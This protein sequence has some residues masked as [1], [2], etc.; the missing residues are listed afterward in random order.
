MADEIRVN[1]DEPRW[2]Q[3]TYWGRAQYFFTTTNPLNIF[4]S[5]ARLDQ[6][7]QIVDTYKAGGKLPG[8][9]LEELYRAKDLVDSA[10]HPETGEKMIIIGRMSAQVPMNMVIT[11]CMITF[12]KTAPAVVFWQWVNQ[13]FNALV[14]YTNRSG[15]SPMP[16]DQVAKSYLSAT[17]GALV[18]ALSLNKLVKSAPPLV[19]RLVPFTAV[20][21]A[22][23]INIPLMRYKEIRDGISVFD[24]NNNHLGDSPTAAKI[25]ISAVVFSR[26]LMA[27]PG[28]VLTPV[29]VDQLE[30]KGAFARYPRMVGPLQFILC[31]I[32]LSFTTPM[33]CALFPQ[34]SPIMI[35]KLEQSIQ[36]VATALSPKPEIAYYNKGL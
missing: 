6:C 15:S 11:A 19:G 18:T 20:A 34:K 29:I 25:G 22:N 7:K 4:T 16:L 2:D 12:Y 5:S 23:C 32:F 10:F 14:N 35:A 26:I 24:D 36:N 31:G 8:V 17:G 30:R 27:T 3:N 28:M 1:L 9:S 13:S 33:C 21:A